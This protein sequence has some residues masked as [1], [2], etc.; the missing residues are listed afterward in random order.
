M[1]TTVWDQRFLIILFSKDVLNW[2][3]VTVKTFIVLQKFCFK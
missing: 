1:Y 3:I 2:S